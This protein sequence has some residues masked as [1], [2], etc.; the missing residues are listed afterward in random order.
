MIGK[1]YSK[2][3]WILPSGEYVECLSREHEQCAIKLGTSER[4]LEKKAIKISWIPE[5]DFREFQKNGI[6]ME[7]PIF[8]PPFE[9]R[10]TE[11]QL[12]TIEEYCRVFHYWPPDDYFLEMGFGEEENW[13]VIV[14]FIWSTQ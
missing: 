13:A 12:K 7:N 5:K 9:S 6:R 14:A 11:E 1:Y 4:E 8:I 3:G 2:S 10:M